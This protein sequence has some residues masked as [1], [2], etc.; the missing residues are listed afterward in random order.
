[1]SAASI[2]ARI[3]PY[4]PYALLFLG[5]AVAIGA[6][7]QALDYPFISDDY[8]YIIGNAKL[9]GL[10]APELWRLLVEPFNSF[11]F[12]PL[13]D[14]S[15]WLDIK[16]FG[17]SGPAFRMHN[18]LLYI[19]CCLLVYVTTLTIWRYFCPGREKDAPWAAASVAALFTIHPA[20]VEAVVWVSGRK[21]LLSG[22]FAL[23][24]LWLALNVKRESGFS[25]RY[26]SAALIALLAAMLSKAT[27]IGMAPIIAILWI[28]FW[29]GMP[30]PSRRRVTLI[31]PLAGM[32]LAAAAAVAFNS[33]ST[34][35]APAYWGVETVTRTFAIIGWMVRL[36]LSP[37]SRHYFYPVFEDRW[38]HWMVALGVA[39]MLAAITAIVLLRQRP[40]L[41]FCSIAFVL[42]CLPYVQLMPFGTDSLVTDRFLFL[43]VW[44]ILLALVWVVWRL[45]P[46]ARTVILLVIAAPW[47][48]Q[49]IE[50]TK[51][52]RSYEAFVVSDMRAFPGYFEPAAAYITAFLGPRGL[53]REALE[54]ANAITQPD[55][56]KIMIELVQADNVVHDAGLS[57]G[58]LNTIVTQLWNLGKDLGEIP[59]EVNWNYPIAFP[60][61]EGNK[62]LDREW[63]ILAKKFPDDLSVRYNAGSWQLQTERYENAAF[64]FRAALESQ[65]LPEDARATVLKNLG[66]ALL[67]AGHVADAEAPLRAALQQ[68]RP[69][70][71]ANCPLAAGA[72]AERTCR[73]SGAVR[74]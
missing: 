27:A 39:A 50:R 20:H 54:T 4:A 14:F 18:I 57:A 29:R 32:L 45:N 44:P 34:V 3:R 55:V 13:R 59:V 73:G 46:A 48:Y 8:T 60:Y 58:N 72:A 17:L 30:S 51:D 52:W 56:R 15:Y 42:L 19:L 22:M 35:K 69:D 23:L 6:Y 24:A 1:M 49:T 12:L 40:I 10:H 62:I 26:A 37:E 25:A 63:M 70:L 9:A 21:D 16:L 74:S 47:I 7:L 11:E 43:A 71:E 31:W 38:L 65:Q 33:H 5:M 53:M 66:V 61:F 41:R 28:M 2:A 67:K 64:N 68:A 36:A